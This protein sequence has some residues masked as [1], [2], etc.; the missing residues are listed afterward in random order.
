MASSFKQSQLNNDMQIDQQSVIDEDELQRQLEEELANMEY[1]PDPDDLMERQSNYSIFNQSQSN[2]NHNGAGATLEQSMNNMD[3][4]VEQMLQKERGRNKILQDSAFR[5]TNQAWKEFLNIQHKEVADVIPENWNEELEDLKRLN[6]QELDGLFVHQQEI[7]QMNMSARSGFSVKSSVS[8]TPQQI[9][10]KIQRLDSQRQSTQSIREMGQTIPKI[11]KQNIKKKVYEIPQIVL[12]EDKLIESYNHQI[13]LENSILKSQELV[14]ASINFDQYKSS[15]DQLLLNRQEDMLDRINVVNQGLKQMQEYELEI[16][17]L[18]ME[19]EDK[20]SREIEEY[21]HRSKFIQK[22]MHPPFLPPYLTEPDN[23]LKNKPVQQNPIPSAPM[24]DNFV[25]YRINLS[26]SLPAKIQLSS[27]KILWSRQKQEEEDE[28]QR[29][30]FE[31]QRR[32]KEH[33][34]LSELLNFSIIQTNK[35]VK[36]NQD[37]QKKQLKQQSDSLGKFIQ[38]NKSNIK[39]IVEKQAKIIEIELKPSIVGKDPK[40]YESHDDIFQKHLLKQHQELSSNLLKII[41]IL[42][43]QQPQLRDVEDPKPKIVKKQ[44]NQ[45]RNKKLIKDDDF[46]NMPDLAASDSLISQALEL[47][48]PPNPTKAE[49]IE[50]KNEQLSQLDL[51]PLNTYKNLQQ[52]NL[53]MNKI[54]TIQPGTLDLPYL[55]QLRL[56]DN[57]IK[58]IPNGMFS[59]SPNLRI[60]Y[61]DINQLK[62]VQNLQNLSN[63][64][65]LSIANNQIGS[66]DGIQSLTKLRR[67][68]LSFNKVTK[69]DNHLNNLGF[70][71]YLELGKNFISNIDNFPQHKLLY[72][73]ELYI[74]SNQLVQ[75]PKNFAM[76]Q[77]KV[78]N[79]NRNQDLH[80]LSLG[81]NPL[82]EQLNASYCSL[83]Q[84]KQLSGCPNLR[85]FDVSFNSINSLE[86][87]M[88]IINSCKQ[89]RN[90]RFSDNPFSVNKEQIYNQHFKA[91]FTY[92]ERVNG[93][94][95][96]SSS[97]KIASQ[98]NQFGLEMRSMLSLLAQSV[99]L[100]Q[101]VTKL[102][103]QKIRITFFSTTNIMKYCKAMMPFILLQQL[104]QS[105]QM[106]NVQSKISDILVQNHSY[107]QQLRTSVR[108]ITSFM[109][110]RRIKRKALLTKMTK[111]VPKLVKIQALIKGHLSRMKNQAI[112]NKIKRD[113]PKKTKKYQ[114]MSK[115]QANIKGFLFR[116]R[117]IRA[118]DKLNQKKKNEFED[119]FEDE[120]DADKFFGI[121]EEVLQNG[122][123]LPEE[124]M[125]QQMI[126]MMA[127]QNQQIRKQP[128]GSQMTVK[129]GYNDGVKFPPINQKNQTQSNIN[130]LIKPRSMIQ[131]QQKPGIN[132]GNRPP[133]ARSNAISEI[134]MNSE[135][136]QYQPGSK[137]NSQIR[138]NNLMSNTG[139]EYNPHHMPSIS[140]NQSRFNDDISDGQSVYSM[141]SNPFY[142]SQPNKQNYLEKMA[143]ERKKEI[144]K[145][146][147]VI[148]EWG[149][150][151]EETK[152]MFE[153]RLKQKN[154]GKKKQ[155]TAD[156]K[157]Q[158]FKALRKN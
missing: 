104:T 128:L 116:K 129:E 141:N 143:E 42:K 24:T 44:I 142:P 10:T 75:L 82:L 57:L 49:K 115:L 34:I 154:K 118:L 53:S 139:N 88:Q 17:R 68:N 65:E 98:Q 138:K 146:K 47:H 91:I 153:A 25:K 12:A 18:V 121:K 16:E 90:L 8:Q 157:L 66:L 33:K 60:L 119:D 109:R 151:N 81:Y 64:E 41:P 156:E 117:R 48:A 126:Q 55:S 127:M 147:E 7:D 58:E 145:N 43:Q 35:L 83:V 30:E 59:K 23:P 74:Y 85:E 101:F 69:I 21:M 113:G 11:K 111:H 152:K 71:E 134:D 37:D 31:K 131:N 93:E 51:N 4:Y 15:Q 70:L 114:Q 149:F 102:T 99:L 107:V 14:G 135:N 124:Q 155:L 100:R 50:I 120:F 125:M 26:N 132:R 28:K 106:Q 108:I 63:L 89:M 130:E 54:Q 22:D 6:L 103:S 94:Q 27:V 39:P 97:S 20:L 92:L 144:T 84:I 5:E 61:L 52:L 133:S 38:V 1:Q 123:S 72:L 62:T 2:F 122:L 29:M 45:N 136:Q 56:S 96:Q 79:L 36:Q 150:Q 13:Q 87:F 3:D 67:L 46:M 73:T 76:P 77:L 148:D 140:G 105:V 32:E 86:G 95:I 110:K 137:G 158:K 40:L 112:V 19:R 9:K 78:L 80:Q